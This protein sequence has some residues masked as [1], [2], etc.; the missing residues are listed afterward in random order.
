MADAEVEVLRREVA[1]LTEA[2]RQETYRADQIAT[3][4]DAWCERAQL[5]ERKV[6]DLT[7]ELRAQHEALRRGWTL[8]QYEWA[9]EHPDQ[10][11]VNLLPRAVGRSRNW[12]WASD[13]ESA[14]TGGDGYG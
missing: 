14:R 12:E 4:H 2:L 3:H 7:T 6:E 5:A 10:V 9:L 11:A 8:P 13:R 1:R